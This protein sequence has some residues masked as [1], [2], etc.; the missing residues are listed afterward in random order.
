MS[1]PGEKYFFGKGLESSENRLQKRK[2]N[3]L[4]INELNRVGLP[5]ENVD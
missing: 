3:K 1:S 2:L 4:F 5:L